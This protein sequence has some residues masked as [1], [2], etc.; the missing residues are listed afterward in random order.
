M[1]EKQKEITDES[2]LLAI[3]KFANKIFNRY[4]KI[5]TGIETDFEFD[6]RVVDLF[7]GESRWEYSDDFRR[8]YDY[9]LELIP[10]KPFPLYAFVNKT[11]GLYD[12]Y[13]NL[14]KLLRDGHPYIWQADFQ[15]MFKKDLLMLGFNLNNLSFGSS[16]VQI[17]NIDTKQG[18]NR[19]Q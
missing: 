2:V 18:F 17:R 7:D 8:N 4:F 16:A 13:Y 14:T 12:D 9:V 10:N 3:Q 11:D 6:V 1:G 5:C 19:P 15:K